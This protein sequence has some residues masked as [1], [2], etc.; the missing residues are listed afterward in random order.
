LA[1]CL[2]PFLTIPALAQQGDSR[3]LIAVP[4]EAVPLE[5][6]VSERRML[7]GRPAREAILPSGQLSSRFTL[8]DLRVLGEDRLRPLP[9]AVP[10]PEDSGIQRLILE[11]GTF[12]TRYPDGR[13]R[14]QRPDGSI[15]TVAPDGTVSM[16]L[17]IQVPGADLPL[18]PE[19][20]SG[21]GSEL[22]DQLMGLLRNILSEAE[23]DAYRQTEEDKAYYDRIDWRLRSLN[24]LTASQ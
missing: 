20:L 5:N 12:E 21:W 10:P 16:A 11:D 7:E 3:S 19:E 4:R 14:R 1:L 2:F 23:F 18:L 15:E 13:I 8:G 17:A 6:A 24:F 9:P 22:G